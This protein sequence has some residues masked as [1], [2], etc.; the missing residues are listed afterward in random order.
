MNWCRGP[1]AALLVACV[2]ACSAAPARAVEPYPVDVVITLSGGGTF[3]GKAEQQTLQLVES[4]VN[5]QGGIKGQPIHFVIHDDAS[6]PATAVQFMNALVAAKTPVVLGS[7]LA[8][9]CLAMA[10]LAKNGPVQYCLSPAIHPAKDSYVFSASSSTRDFAV[11]FFRYFRGIGIKRVA[12]ISSTDASG[13][14]ADN[15]F[16]SVLASP[17][18]SASGITFVDR[19]HFTT[20]D[21]DVGAQMAR[22]KAANPQVVICYAPGT[23]FGTLLRGVQQAGIDVPIA[24]GNANMVYAEMKQYAAILPKELWFPGLAVLGGIAPDAKW[25]DAQ[26]T[27]LDAYKTTGTAPDMLATIAWDPAM[28]VVDAL[29][30]YGTAAS[31][32]QIRS[33]IASLH[34][35]TGVSGH[36]DFRDG[37]QRGIGV[38]SLVIMRWDDGKQT[39]TALSEP[40][41]FTHKTH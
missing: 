20:T 10:P 7:T 33:Y 18:F 40:G 26:Q 11:S 13:Q 17:E 36:Y 16:A 31:A 3:I 15:E 21:L 28:I 4:V 30:R 2:L 34:D 12:M 5:K 32:D 14:D 6:Q 29:R 35:Y 41:G 22:I 9:T 24:T 19:E 1:G 38:D 23:P 39:W 25:R 37:S 8:A 27:F